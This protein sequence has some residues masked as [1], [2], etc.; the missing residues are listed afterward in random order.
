MTCK[1]LHGGHIGA[2]DAWVCGQCF[3]LLAGRP[4][5]YGI[6]GPPG[7]KKTDAPRARQQIVWQA[8]TRKSPEGTT[9]DQFLRA[10]ARR[11]MS[12]C[13]DLDQREAHKLALDALKGMEAEFGHPDYDWSRASAIDIAD[14]EMT[15][16]DEAEEQGN[17]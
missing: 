9:L 2:L 15:Y 8:E 11:F 4:K 3:Q 7:T 5:R 10:M 12:Q 13:K 1:H 6:V 17:G 16:W 14:E